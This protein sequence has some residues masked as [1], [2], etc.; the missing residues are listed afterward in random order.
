VCLKNTREGRIPGKSPLKEAKTFLSKK[1]HEILRKIFPP[2]RERQ[3]K[4]QQKVKLKSSSSE[5]PMG[6]YPASLE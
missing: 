4:G 2:K 1:Y 5:S 6:M 3:E